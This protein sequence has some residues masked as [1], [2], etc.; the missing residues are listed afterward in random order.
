MLAEDRSCPTSPAACQVEP[1]VNLL[2]SISSTSVCPMAPK[3]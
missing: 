1:D 2:R 3:W